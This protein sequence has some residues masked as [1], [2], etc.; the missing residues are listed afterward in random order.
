MI[1]Y[2]NAFTWRKKRWFIAYFNVDALYFWLKNVTG[3][4]NWYHPFFWVVIASLSFYFEEA[5]LNMINFTEIRNKYWSLIRFYVK[6]NIYKNGSKYDLRTSEF[7]AI[8]WIRWVEIKTKN[9]FLCQLFLFIICLDFLFISIIMTDSHLN[10]IP[11]KRNVIFQ[12]NSVLRKK[13]Q[14][15]ITN[16]RCS[17]EI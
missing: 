16:G 1:R 17:S 10:A 15:N 2:N 11:S 6:V 3:I 9:I 4:W 14:L 5:F 12:S 7:W 8:K 13:F